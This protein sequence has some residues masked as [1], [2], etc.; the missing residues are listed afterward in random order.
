V[1][2]H[3]YNPSLSL[4]TGHTGVKIPDPFMAGALLPLLPNTN[5]HSK[6]IALCP[7]GLSSIISTLK[8][9]A[10]EYYLSEYLDWSFVDFILI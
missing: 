1:G 8:R 3:Q 10:W 6:H 7:P 2:P 4:L 5:P 9:D